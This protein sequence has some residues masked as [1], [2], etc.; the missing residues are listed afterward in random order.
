MAPCPWPVVDASVESSG[1]RKG[2][3]TYVRGDRDD[4]ER[5]VIGYVRV[6]T[7]D[8]AASGL[9]LDAQRRA[10]ADEVDRRGWQLVDV[11]ADEG[12]TGKTLDRPGLH[13]ALTAIAERR[14]D[15]LL[16][17]K[18]DRVS[19]SVVD[20]GTLLDWFERAG[21]AFVAFD[22][23]VD[24]STPAGRLVA[25]VLA[26]VAEW[27]AATISARTRDGLAAKRERGERISRGAVTDSAD[28]VDHIREMR[29][30]GLTLQA[31]ADALNTVGVPTVRGGA[32]WRPSSVQT[33]LGYRRPSSRHSR[34]DLPPTG[35]TTRGRAA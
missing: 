20:F 19:R 27:E 28:L 32:L 31:I 1:I 30:S 3:V 4:A 10:I 21:A 23:G 14:A 25:N 26:S 18:L 35:R 24:T 12:A 16:V 34:S 11:V 13:E 17:A 6:S 9:G 22:L 29:A 8:Q 7:A 2:S 5:R 33:V 15:T